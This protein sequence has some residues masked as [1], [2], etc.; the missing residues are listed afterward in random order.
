M[1]KA[2]A[3][4]AKAKQRTELCIEKMAQNEAD[5]G[6]QLVAVDDPHAHAIAAGL[7]LPVQ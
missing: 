3:R 4:A 2:R 6:Q 5:V 7:S 1:T